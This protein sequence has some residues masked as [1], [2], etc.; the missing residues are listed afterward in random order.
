MGKGKESVKVKVRCGGWF[1]GCRGSS[2]NRVR[3]CRVFVP[4]RRSFSVDSDAFEVDLGAA[5]VDSE[6][7]FLSR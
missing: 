1:R 3:D 4:F 7:D 6:A 2:E 5:E